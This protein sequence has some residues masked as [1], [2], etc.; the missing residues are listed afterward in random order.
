MSL[1]SVTV[2]EPL[3]TSSGNVAGRTLPGIRQVGPRIFAE[4]LCE[5]LIAEP[6]VRAAVM[7]WLL[8]LAEERRL[9]PATI[10]GY[11]RD[12][13]GWLRFIAGDLGFK[14]GIGDLAGLA[15]HDFRRYLAARE[16]GGLSRTSRARNIAAIRNLFRYLERR[17]LCR[18]VVAGTLKAGRLP[19]NVPRAL[20]E[21][22]ARDVVAGAQE[23]GLTPWVAKRDTAVLLVL[24]GC[25]LRISEALGLNRSEAVQFA[26]GTIRICGKGDKERLVPVLPVVAEAVRDYLCACP[27]PL[28]EHDPLFIGERGRRLGP[29]LIQARVQ[30]LR[31]QFDLPE[32]ATPHALRHS[33]ATHLLGGGGDLR[34]I[35]ELLGHTSLSATQRYTSVDAKRLQSVYDMAHPR[36]RLESAID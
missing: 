36:A 32:T 25:G 34:T 30:R 16:H 22:D 7:S 11:G 19:R 2:S 28:A 6:A 29:R 10:D 15:A 3:M 12:I 13:V 18:N 33:F 14:P 23:L 21:H 1:S 27:Y 31:K 17:D 20:D 9:S 35:Q 8:W 26:S 4:L 24:Y 5:T